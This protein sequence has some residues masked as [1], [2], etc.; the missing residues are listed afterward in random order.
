MLIATFGSLY[1]ATAAYLLLVKGTGGHPSPLLEL[2]FQV[3]VLGCYG[4][5][6]FLLEDLFCRERPSPV[7]AFWHLIVG[8]V[9]FAALF[10]AVV[11]VIPGGFSAG[12]PIAISTVVQS[13]LVVPVWVA[14]TILL[15]LAVPGIDSTPKK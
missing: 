1:L 4:S 13:A 8:A 6:W 9:V 7:Q 12:Q 11:T 14:F 3:F 2:V 10:I 5:L 15:L